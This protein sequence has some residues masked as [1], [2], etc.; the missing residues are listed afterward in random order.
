[1]CSHIG[2][3]VLTNKLLPLMK[4]TAA[5]PNSDVRIVTVAS[6]VHKL[7]PNAVFNTKEDFNITYA[8]EDRANVDSLINRS[9]RYMFSKLLNVLFASELQRRL[10]SESLLAEPSTN[11]IISVSVHPGLVATENGVNNVPWVLRFIL[12]SLALSP[13][14]GASAILF[15]ATSVDVREQQ[16]KYMGSYLE[17]GGVLAEASTVAKDKNLAHQLWNL[18]ESFVQ[19]L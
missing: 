13:L 7:V 3:F 5:L 8:S 14:Q 10:L 19:S 2:H 6:K 17:E 16:T 11:S 1:L 4:S 15:A 18:T 9:K 12:R